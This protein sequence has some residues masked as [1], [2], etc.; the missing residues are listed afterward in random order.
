MIC[1]IWD[2]FPQYAARCVGAFVKAST[3][4][5]VVVATRPKVPIEGME[6]VCGC[7]VHWVGFDEKRTLREI[8]GEVPRAAIVSGWF[9]SLFNR[10]RDEVRTQGGKAVAMCDNNWMGLSLREFVKAVRFKLLFRNKYDGFFV[11]GASGV[12]LLRFYGVAREKIATGMYSADAS[13]FRDGKPLPEREKKI[14]YVGQFIERKNVRRLVEAF[15]R[16]R[17]EVDI[18]GSNSGCAD[19]WTLELYG[20]G[21]LKDELV[22]LASNL[23]SQ[24]ST[25][26][27]RIS[28]NDFVQPEQLFGLYQSARLF[29]LPSLWEHWGLVVHEA[30]LSGCPLLLSKHIGAADD[31]LIEGKNGWTFDQYSVDDMAL[32]LKR[33]MELDDAD[34][35]AM[36]TESLLMAK[37]ASLEKFVSGVKKMIA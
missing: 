32:V 12:K 5:V 37:N 23:N 16:S 31:L 2:G 25:F 30:T 15:Y 10:W 24:L 22:N 28:V 26:N 19:G 4:K 1:F 8:L 36:Q 11:P 17:K 9:S 27:S 6:K 33:A 21:P 13:I 14:I 29:C 34:L 3:E 35:S 7:P 20:S 18:G